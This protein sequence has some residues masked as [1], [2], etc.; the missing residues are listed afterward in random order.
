MTL[1]NAVICSDSSRKGYGCWEALWGRRRR[2]TV[3]KKKVSEEN[4]PLMFTK[5]TATTR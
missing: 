1:N 4:K 5:I 2:K 3:K